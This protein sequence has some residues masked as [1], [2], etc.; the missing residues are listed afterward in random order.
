MVFF[1]I[2]RMLSRRVPLFF[3]IL[4]SALGL[5]AAE[6]TISVTATPRYPWNGK[7]D[8]K[9]TIAG[10]SGTKYDT[11]FTAKDVA[12]GTNLTMKT[13]Y[14]S[15]GA[16]ANVGKEALLPGTYNW[17]WDA[18]ED[19]THR[20]ATYSGCLPTNSAVLFSNVQL[21]ELSEFYA[22]PCGKAVSDKSNLTKGA[23]I[24]DDGAGKSVQFAFSDDAYTKCVCVHLEQS[25][26]NVVGYAKWARYVSGTGH[27][28]SD[29]DTNSATELGIA[30]SE[31]E[32][33]YG[34]LKL[35]AKGAKHDSSTALERVV[36]EGKTVKILDINDARY[37]VID[38]SG[39]SSAT[40]YPVSYLN[41]APS[42]GFTNTP[43]RTTKL[44]LRRIEAGSFILGSDQVNNAHKVTLTKPF[45]MGVFEVTQKQYSLIMGSN[46]SSGYGV[47]DGYPVYNVSYNILR[48]TSSGAKWPASS[49]VDSSSFI[50]KLR[51]RTSLN[52]DLPTEAQWEYAYRAGTTTT[53]YWGNSINGDYVWYSSNSGSTTHPVGTKKPNGWGLYDMSGNVVEWCLDWYGA[54]VTY[55]TDP[56]GPSSGSARVL[57]GGAFD[58]DGDYCK[59]SACHFGDPNARYFSGSG[60]PRTYGVGVRLKV[61]P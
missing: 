20:W 21:S 3:A 47:G 45:Y 39:G 55:G 8:L 12:G 43:Y 2:S 19:L 56:K 49:A 7:V 16:A 1:W 48:G 9:F 51:S 58:L 40:S 5:S 27:E 13:L 11:S 35:E 28:K 54:S 25:G 61:S 4:V 37:M 36:V 57:R 60:G 33:G 34:L 42:N 31:T 52:F 46:P 50:G 44:V 23:Y 24:K 17:V 10:T 29:F 38:L 59:A 41:A 14:K 6:P 26:A 15:N 22:V 30:T 32:A 53:Y 18:E